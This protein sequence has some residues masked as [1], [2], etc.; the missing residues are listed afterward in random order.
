MFP[1]TP[2]LVEYL[3]EKRKKPPGKKPDGNG[4]AGI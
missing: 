4:D 3:V 2:F 1:V